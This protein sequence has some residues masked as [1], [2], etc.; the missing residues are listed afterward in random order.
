[1]PKSAPKSSAEPPAR[2]SHSQPQRRGQPPPVLELGRIASEA[3][4]QPD[5]PP[6]SDGGLPRSP[7]LTHPVLRLQRAAGNRATGRWL[8]S[9]LVQAKLQINQPGDIYE[10]EA[11]RV[12]DAVIRRQSVAATLRASP[13]VQRDDAPSPPNE[14]QQLVEPPKESGRLTPEDMARIAAQKPPP[15]QSDEMKKAAEKTA[16]ALRKTKIGKELEDKAAELGKDFVST[17]EGKIITGTAVAGALT[18]L[19][20]ADAPLPIQPPE[21]PLDWLATGLKGKL[22][23]EGPVRHPSKVFLS[24]TFTP[25]AEEKH[26]ARES[27]AERNRAET[28]RIA[29]DMENFRRHMSFTPGSAEDLA[30]KAEDA[31]FQRWA[32]SRLGL[33]SA[34]AADAIQAAPRLSTFAEDAWKETWNSYFRAKRHPSLMGGELELRPLTP[35]ASTTPSTG[36]AAPQPVQRKES[37]PSTPP[38]L[39][40]PSVDVA[41]RA[42]GQALDAGIRRSM[43]TH[44]GRDFSHV[45]IHADALA[46]ESADEIHAHAYTVGQDVVFGA[47]QYTPGTTSGARLLAHELAHIVQQGATGPALNRQAVEGYQSKGIDLEV[48][49]MNKWTGRSFWEQKVMKTFA[50]A[51]DPR[52]S[53]DPEERDAVLSVVDNVRPKLPLASETVRLVSIPKRAS[54]AKS[55]D[56]IYQFSFIPKATGKPEV[57]ARFVAESAAATVTGATA[58]G[59][60]LTPNWPSLHHGGFPGMDIKAYWKAHPDEEQ[61]VFNWIQNVAGRAFDQVITASVTRGVGKTAVTRETS[62]Q[63]QGAKDASGTITSLTI[64]FLGAVLPT[65]QTPPADYASRDFAD[66]E[67]EEAQTTNDPKKGDKLGTING[68]SKVPGSEQLSVK[69]AIWQYF[70]GGT[71]NA[72]VDAIVPIANTTKRVLYTLVFRAKTNDVDIERIGEEGKDV[73]LASPPLSLSHVNG[74]AANSKDVSTLKA[75]LSKRYPGVKPTGA[76]VDDVRKS[77]DAQI[78]ADAGKPAWFLSNY[79]IEI[80]DAAAGAARLKEK[81]SFGTAQLVDMKLFTAGELKI[82]ESVLETM[83]DKL[84]A[85]FK[86]IRMVRQAV[87]IKRDGRTFRRDPKES[88]LSNLS[89]TDRTIIIFDNAHLNDSTLFLGGKGA[90]GLATAEPSAAMTFAHEFGHT[91]SWGSG[92]QKAFDAF[93]AQKRIKPPTWYAASAQ[94]EMFPESFAL[95][96]LDPEW[97]KSNQP[98]LFAWFDTLTKT[99]APPAAQPA[100]T[101]GGT[102]P[103]QRKEAS[104]AGPV[105]GVPPSVEEV[106]RSPGMLLDT[107][108]RSL[109]EGRFARDFGGVRIHADAPAARSAASVQALA[110][111]VGRDIV[112]GAGR[113]APGTSAGGRLLAHELTHVVQQDQM[114]VPLIQRQKAAPAATR[115]EVIAAFRAEVKTKDWK[116]AARHLNGLGDEDIAGRLNEVNHDARTVLYAGALEGMPGYFERVT[117]AI[118]QID[119]EAVRV[120]QLIFEYDTAVE[121]GNWPVAAERLNAFNDADIRSHLEHLSAENLESIKG[122][123]QGRFDRIAGPAAAVGQSRALA[124][125]LD[126]IRSLRGSTTVDDAAKKIQGAL[127]G[128]NLLDRNNLTAIVN[129]ISAT[130]G[131][132]SG[133]ILEAFLSQ[134]EASMPPRQPTQADIAREQRVESLMQIG[135][136]G[137]YKQYAPGVVLPVL[138]QPGRHLVPAVEAAGNAFAGAAGFVEGLLAGLAGALDEEHRQ[139]LATRLKQSALLTAVFPVIFLAGTV[140]GVVE[141]VVD[142]VKGV[143]HLFA[144]FREFADAIVTFTRAMLSPDSAEIGGAM[145][146]EIGKDYGAKIAAMAEENVFRF[147]YDLGRMIGPTILYIVL[148][149]LGVPELIAAEIVERMVP[150]LRPLLEKFPRLLKLMEGLAAKLKERKGATIIGKALEKR[151][152]EKAATSAL[153][154][155]L[156]RIPAE[157]GSGNFKWVSFETALAENIATEGK[158]LANVMA[159]LSGSDAQLRRLFGIAY[160]G[161]NNKKIWESVLADIAREAEGGAATGGFSHPQITS[162]YSQAIWNMSRQKAATRMVVVTP[163][164]QFF[165]P[166]APFGSRF[167]DLG[168]GAEHGAMAHMAQDLVIDQALRQAG[169]SVD[170][171]ALRRM[172]GGAKGT[173]QGAELRRLLWN[174]LFDANESQGRMNAPEKVTELLR[175]VFGKVD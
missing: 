119:K 43:E 27:E 78:Q 14:R 112:F 20:A 153:E 170:A 8:D 130:F 131:R 9:R 107:G 7:R 41:L 108:T 135:P 161:L 160:N 58:P 128:V 12:A 40:P 85:G 1:M 116:A 59:A 168:V 86:D 61:Q 148:S 30:Q 2:S 102:K 82:L 66:L 79:G 118:A 72:E 32:T 65:K 46:A 74:F 6:P 120:G 99:G 60:T 17:L 19:I 132:D 115:D 91:V 45:K 139:R 138:T 5:R 81:H 163:E 165:G 92:V 127:K 169:E 157:I 37:V 147:T 171:E 140:V 111:T 123:A 87:A 11:D 95:Y 114:P 162:K 54:A 31:D 134:V 173:Y 62:F 25:G 175:A 156:K 35:P 101:T 36:G 53:A 28:A 90:G 141:D 151:A 152:A 136:R 55:K 68:L 69:F 159:A 56:L 150:I 13:V 10:Q 33:V 26:K 121:A 67:I 42:P 109:M 77:V 16:E 50:L 34:P 70:R 125:G 166:Q 3:Y 48:T 164:T 117:G 15:T 80:L 142:A 76:S 106:L 144:N 155:L 51:T 96:Q 158:G 97:M 105:R 22:S 172:I 98:D 39:A 84:V 93:V 24:L 49:E 44:F 110:Y 71:R 113:Y 88:G 133:P 21:I 38:R 149:F 57:E 23:W 167:L 129:V 4:A 18:G 137:P 64:R 73:S 126:K 63:V 104:A 122:A 47:G 154:T 124:E 83:S 89:G 145:G 103:V 52:M 143:Y 174:A 94:A 75:W 146:K 29:A 100:A